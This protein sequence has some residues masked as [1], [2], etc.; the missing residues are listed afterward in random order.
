METEGSSPG[1]RS[2]VRRKLAAIFAADVVGFSRLM[3]LDEEGTLL[4][5]AD[6]R[7]TMDAIISKR[8][9]RIANTA[10]DS[11]LA[12]FES[13]VEA[14][15]CAVE[16]QEA[17]RSKNAGVPD[18]R[19]LQFRIGINVGDV[20][21]QGDDLLGDGVNVASRLEA[22]AEPGGFAFQARYANRSKEN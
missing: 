13:S 20:M 19:V 14:V 3:S 10:G 21:V 1:G 7:V 2:A 15:R 9:G 18:D 6:H 4:R 8:G 17:L 16:V 5:L 12:E 22:L 11:V